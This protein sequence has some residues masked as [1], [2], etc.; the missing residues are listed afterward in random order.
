MRWERVS[1]RETASGSLVADAGARTEEP[2]HTSGLDRAESAAG[3]VTSRY[4]CAVSA[5][6][7][8]RTP[9]P[10]AQREQDLMF[11]GHRG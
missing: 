3:R 2:P 7:T 4:R 1:P 10:H 9:I 6:A 8:S 5:S 11:S